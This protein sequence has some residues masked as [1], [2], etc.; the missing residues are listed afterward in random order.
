MQNFDNFI[1]TFSKKISELNY[2]EVISKQKNN[3]YDINKHFSL[4]K[5]LL[6]LLLKRFKT[7]MVIDQDLWKELYFK[8][9]FFY[10]NQN[11][12]HNI[13]L[14]LVTKHNQIIPF[15][16]S[17]QIHKNN[18][19][20]VHFDT[21]SDEAPVKNSSL[22]PGL[23]NNYLAADNVEKNIYLNKAQDI[24]WDIGA[25][26]SG[27]L[28]TTGIRDVTWCLPSWVP[29]KYISVNTFLK[30][31]KKNIQLS[32]TDNIKGINN[33][34][35]LTQVKQQ[36]NISSAIYTK[37]QTGK[38]S[39]NNL[40]KLLQTIKKNS[41]YFLDIDLDY[42][43]CN[44]KPF[45]KSY[46]KDTFDISSYFRI[47]SNEPNQISPRYNGDKTKEL[48]QY[49]KKFY[50]EIKEIDTRIKNLFKILFYIKKH[51][52]LPSLISICDST[53]VQFQ[54]CNALQL[55]SCNSVSNNYVPLNIALYVHT[56]VLSNIEKL[57][58]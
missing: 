13:P 39:K 26:N 7:K 15:Y 58:S 53:N 48:L 25:A 12:V 54:D 47:Q 20:L 50:K 8:S 10:K 42:I 27:I 45:D 9:I 55:K 30:K 31:T 43:V 34:D 18:F 28:Y 24:V 57:T 14:K 40:Y 37:L 17:Q 52:F 21:H 6:S 2:Y 32:T 49:T 1:N 51:N 3:N 44:G 4:F 19:T 38:L 5:E 11:F 36:T 16:M 35:E 23:Y 33:L 46:Y 56:K 41:G 29:D 22:L